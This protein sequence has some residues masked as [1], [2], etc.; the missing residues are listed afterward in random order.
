MDSVLQLVL[1]THSETQING[2]ALRWVTQ[3]KS[4]TLTPLFYVSF[5]QTKPG[6]E[7]SDV[8]E[9]CGGRMRQYPDRFY[10]R[11]EYLQRQP[12]TQFQVPK[13]RSVLGTSYVKKVS[14]VYKCRASWETGGYSK[15][16][17]TSNTTATLTDTTLTNKHNLVLA[18]RV[19]NSAKT[20]F[21]A[22]PRQTKTTIFHLL[23]NISNYQQRS[24]KYAQDLRN[25][26]NRSRTV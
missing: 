16:S 5:T 10:S 25:R 1:R 13:N 12:R 18:S 22:F 2:K 23:L 6:S 17:Y 20:V 9:D 8:M 14:L 26:V 11:V 3:L 24:I 19:P 21:Q 4:I 15:S 7:W